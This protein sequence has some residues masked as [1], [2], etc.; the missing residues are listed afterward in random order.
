MPGVRPG[1]GDVHHLALSV[2]DV[3]RSAAWYAA[4]LGFERLAERS[5]EQFRRLL[6]RHPD[7]GL[8]LTLLSH[9]GSRPVPFDETRTGLD[10]LAFRVPSPDDVDAWK[11]W[12]EGRHV[13]CSDVK[14][15]ALPD[16]RLITFRDPDAIQIECYFSR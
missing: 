10:H 6:L 3:D 2:T 14:D 11:R 5:T 7:S 8:L 13:A 15:G 12:L 16:S 1:L 9:H 4:M